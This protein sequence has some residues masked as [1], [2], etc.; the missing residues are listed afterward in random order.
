MS[1]QF[2][3]AFF[4]VL[5]FL[6]ARS[7]SVPQHTVF[8]NNNIAINELIAHQNKLQEFAINFEKNRPFHHASFKIRTKALNNASKIDNPVVAIISQLTFSYSQSELLPHY[9]FYKDNL[10]TKG[11]SLRGPP[12]LG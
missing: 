10:S 7:Y 6:S 11:V 3:I 12:S 9:L 5:I 4:S 2:Y 1:R 8:C